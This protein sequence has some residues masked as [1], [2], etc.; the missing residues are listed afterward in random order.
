MYKFRSMHPNAEKEIEKIR[1][2][3]EMDGPA[4]KIANDPR[5]TRFGRIIRK[6]GIDE[7]PQFVNVLKGDMSI[8]GPRPPLPEEV[9]KYTKDQ[10]VRLSV[11]PGIT[12]FW[13]IQPHRNQIHFNEWVELDKKYVKEQ[14]FLTD[15]K[16]MF[17]TINTVIHREGL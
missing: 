12:C 2:K 7:I 17:K 13:Q 5:I 9:K 14:G 8:V 3:N 11:M 10:M 6:T 1:Q 15:W 4:F 16:I